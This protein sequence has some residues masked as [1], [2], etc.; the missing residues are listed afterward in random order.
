MAKRNRTPAEREAG[1]AQH[2]AER[3]VA[4]KRK[5][6]KNAAPPPGDDEIQAR[7]E[8]FRIARERLDKAEARCERMRQVRSVT[9][10]GLPTLGKGSK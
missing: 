9:S 2:R 7:I 10:G 8:E 5:A 3:A 6:R 1:Q 4:R